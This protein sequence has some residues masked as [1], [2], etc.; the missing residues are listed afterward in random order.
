MEG[1][2]DVTA[3]MEELLER[4]RLLNYEAVLVQQKGMKPITIA[5]FAVPL[6]QSEQFNYFKT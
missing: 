3:Q 6:N 4:L 2:E 5:Y 1:N